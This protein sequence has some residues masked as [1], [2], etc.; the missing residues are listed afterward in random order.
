[1][2]LMDDALQPFAVGGLFALDGKRGDENLA[3]LLVGRLGYDLNFDALSRSF[4]ADFRD[5]NIVVA[6]IGGDASRFASAALQTISMVERDVVDKDTFAWGI[7]KLYYSAFYAGHA[8]IRLLGA[9]C[10][11]LDRSHIS[12]V[13]ALGAALGK[14]PGF[15]IETGLYHCHVNATSS[16]FVYERARGSVGGAHES[17]WEIFRQRIRDLMQAVLAGPLD[18]TDADAVF[19]KLRSFDDILST[20]GATAHGALSELRNNVQYRHS[21]GAWFPVAVSKAQR[22]KLSRIASQWQR[23]PMNVELPAAD[24]NILEQFAAACA[25]VVAVCRSLLFRIVQRSSVRDR[26]FIC[27][28]PVAFLRNARLSVPRN[29]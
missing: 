6:A 26:C 25:F 1:M 24:T 12:R 28:G 22:A 4:S 13:T 11:Y 7:V 5:P 27:F 18:R 8:L 21:L 19:G 2:S 20:R 9:S 3:D 10:T 17:F 14:M 29:Y 16:G 15:R 23:D